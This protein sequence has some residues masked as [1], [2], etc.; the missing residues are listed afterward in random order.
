MVLISLVSI[1]PRI[2]LDC[3]ALCLVS[4]RLDQREFRESASARQRERE[5][6]S[7][8]E[9]ARKRERERESEKERERERERERESERPMTV[10]SCSPYSYTSIRSVVERWLHKHT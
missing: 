3:T 4:I 10:R 7:E 1:C 6:E 5:R 2:G 8:K 9:R